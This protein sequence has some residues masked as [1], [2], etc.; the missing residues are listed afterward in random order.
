MDPNSETTLFG[1]AQ[2]YLEEGRLE[3]AV[4]TFYKVVDLKPDYTAAYYNLS[5]ALDK[6]DR[7]EELIKVL[8]AGVR[9]GDKTGDHIPTQRMRA[10]L[11]RIHKTIAGKS[12]DEEKNQS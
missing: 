8:E 2:A 11:R 7:K 5:T 9:V 6:L 12:S 3:E 4:E 1:L 10:R